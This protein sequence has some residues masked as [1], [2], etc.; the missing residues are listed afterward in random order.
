MAY[1]IILG[2]VVVVIRA[3]FD[4]APLGKM[5]VKVLVGEVLGEVS[6]VAVLCEASVGSGTHE[7]F[8]Q[9]PAI[10]PVKF[11]TAGNVSVASVSLR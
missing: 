1:S 4:S 5:L 11:C 2:S 6:S 7:P 9:M 3:R 10:F 8:T